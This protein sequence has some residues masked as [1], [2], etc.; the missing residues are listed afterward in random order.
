MMKEKTNLFQSISQDDR[1]AFDLFYNIYYD[2]VFRIS[3]YFL[4]DKE[5]CRE[6]VSDVFFSVWL[7]RKRLVDIANI[8]AWLYVVTKNEASKYLR[9]ESKNNLVALEDVAIH[10]SAEAEES[11]DDKILHEEIENLLT[12]AINELPERCRAIFVMSRQDGLKPKEI[13]EILSINESTV[14]VQL[15]IALEKIIEI[16]KP[17]FPNIT[18]TS[19]L[20]YIFQIFK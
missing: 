15:K 1:N 7:S 6:V 11:P 12:K 14:R 2:Q 3:Y 13:A 20:I 18:F 17:Y 9:R 16:V 4:K 19:L 5:A 10:I 8:E